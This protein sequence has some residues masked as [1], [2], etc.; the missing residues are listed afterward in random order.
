MTFAQ[1][2]HD[3]EILDRVGAGAMGTV[4]KARQKRLSRIVALKVLRPSL[5]RD[6][7]YVERLRREARIVAALNHPNIV[8]GYD[9]GE[10][11][12]YHFFVMEFIEGKSLRGLLSEWGIFPE[13]QVLKVAI[14]VTF[15]LDHAFQRGV[16]HR[17]IKPGNILIDEQGNVKLTDMGLAKGPADAALT[18]EGSTVGTPQYISPEQAI[19]PQ[20][21][22]IRSDLYSLGATL[23][24]MATGQPPFRGE[25]IAEVITKVLHNVAQSPRSL[26]PAL[27]EGLSLVIRKLL[28]KDLRVRYQTPLELLE[29]LQR[30]Q[31]SKLPAVDENRLLAG[32]VPGR[33]SSSLGKGN[34]ASLKAWVAFLTSAAAC[35]VGAFWYGVHLRVDSPYAQGTELFLSDLSSELANQPTLQAKWQQLLQNEPEAPSGSAPGIEAQRRGIAVLIEQAVAAAVV[36]LQGESWPTTQRWI[37]NPERWPSLIDFER[38]RISKLVLDRTGFL[39]EQLPQSV[40]AASVASLRAA[41]ERAI[42]LRDHELLSRWQSFLAVDLPLRATERS[43]NGDYREADKIWR[44]GLQSFFDGRLQPRLD[45]VSESLKAKANKDFESAK[46]GTRGLPALQAAEQATAASLKDEARAG[47][48]L[49]KERMAL[50]FDPALLR[51]ELQRLRAELGRSYPASSRFRADEDPWREVERWVDACDRELT[52]NAAEAERQ[53]INRLLDLAWLSFGKDPVVAVQTLPLELPAADQR[54]Q[55]LLAEHRKALAAGSRVAVAMVKALQS[56]PV[57]LAAGSGGDPLSVELTAVAHDNGLQLIALD[58]SGLRW[59]AQVTEFRF[60]KLWDQLAGRGELLDVPEGERALGQAVLALAGDDLSNGGALLQPLLSPFLRDEVRPRIEK[61]RSRDASHVT[62][63]AVALA[64]I[65]DAF[66]RASR[67][68]NLPAEKGAGA[69]SEGALPELEAALRAFENPRFKDSQTEADR[70]RIKVMKDWCGSERTRMQEQNGLRDRAPKGAT[71][72]LTPV[73]R[74]DATHY[75]ASVRIAGQPLLAGATD[76]WVWN[77]AAAAVECA[78]VISAQVADMVRCRLEIRSGIPDRVLAVE[79]AINLALPPNVVGSRQYVFEVRGVFVLMLVTADD[80]VRAVTIKGD[81][82]SEAAVH[83]ASL[84]VQELAM[85]SR[86]HAHVLPNVEH[87]LRLSIS[88]SPNR[89]RATAQVFF[90]NVELCKDA[91]VSLDPQQAWNFTAYPLQRM[92]LRA[93]QFTAHDY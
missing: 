9:L 93:I 81:P 22:D 60:G 34:G 3:Y 59:N 86:V 12:G 47:I 70:A 64:R 92:S 33:I 11:G 49:L 71:V 63:Y 56:G 72:E 62:G 2:F 65:E 31:Q 90:D 10:E 43:A 41:V 79:C 32:E 54:Q 67:G 26:N 76:S 53:H 25:T 8:T 74:K 77:K 4:F 55:A 89:T 58:S 46:N 39:P 91:A 18:R 20:D 85:D 1:P 23:Y 84:R 68:D 73:T 28:A 61:M 37:V 38:E 45:K 13:D 40:N 36:E 15:A 30:V 87:Q 17:D 88:A 48:Q 6:E 5:A 42:E 69:P 44:N 78:S 50:Q 24:H 57:R 51:Q 52:L 75:S 7:R 27:S 83:E 14:Q 35:S 19:N 21:V 29:D 82:K 80:N 16:I 66:S